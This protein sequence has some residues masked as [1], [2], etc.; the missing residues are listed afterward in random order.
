M[1]K[2]LFLLSSLFTISTGFLS[3]QQSN[4]QPQ[5]SNRQPQQQ[6]PES[7][8]TQPKGMITPA[9]AP[10]V[11]NGAD[12]I[13]TA[14]FIWWKTNISGMEYATSGVADGGHFVPLGSSTKRGHVHQPNFDFQPGFKVGAG[15]DFAYDGWDLYAD[16]TWLNGETKRNSISAHDG[17]GARNLVPL[18]SNNGGIGQIDIAKESSRWRQH[19]NV[20]DLELGRN[21]FISRFLTLRP[22]FGLKSAWIHEKLKIE[23]KSADATLKAFQKRKQTLW[24]IGTRAGLD[25]VWH[26]AR[27]WGVYGDIAFTAL[28]SDFHFKAKDHVDNMT[29]GVDATNFHTREVIT[30]VIPVFETGI[31]L[32]YMTWFNQDSCQF[33]ISAGWEEQI[34][35]GF[36]H[37][38]DFDRTGNLSVQGLTLKVG[39]VF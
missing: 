3:A 34:W 20:V 27:N 32:T 22:H 26:F 12:V 36:N 24:G 8:T 39:F 38:V 19:F 37:L 5:Q 15:L 18:S 31:G 30:E 35:L 21:F 16:Y 9:V 28:W 14:D 25:T 1:K 11:R 33:V 13:I 7:V 2:H 10:R 6:Q 17:N 23:S 29:T 4:R